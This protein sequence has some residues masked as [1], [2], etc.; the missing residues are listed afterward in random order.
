MY[1]RPGLSAARSAAIH[2]C[3]VDSVRRFRMLRWDRPH[4]AA[5]SRGRS[6]MR[7]GGSSGTFGRK[8]GT[9]VLSARSL[10]GEHGAVNPRSEETNMPAAFNVVFALYPRITQL[11]FTG[12]YE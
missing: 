11:D 3:Q 7:R 12:P 6:G 8:R 10:L 9:C 2:N 5:G 4:R 1:S